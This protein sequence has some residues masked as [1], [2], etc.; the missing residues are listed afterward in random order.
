VQKECYLNAMSEKK[1][2]LTRYKYF[3]NPETKYWAVSEDGHSYFLG[4]LVSGDPRQ[5]RSNYLFRYSG[6][7]H[8]A[9]TNGRNVVV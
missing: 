8:I 4:T 9:K 1:N 3:S 7:T 2:R 6:V 5:G